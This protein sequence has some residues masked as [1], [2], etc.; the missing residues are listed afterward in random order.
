MGKRE[1]GK[2]YG[3]EGREGK[4]RE[5]VIFEGEKNTPKHHNTP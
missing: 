2:N 5:V 3:V 1:R 4:K